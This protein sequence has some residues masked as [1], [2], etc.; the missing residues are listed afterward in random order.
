MS[1]SDPGHASGGQV[2]PD[3]APD[4]LCG[5]SWAVHKPDEKTAVRKACSH[6]GCGCRVYRPD[7]PV[8]VTE[9]A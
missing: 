1:A 2:Y 7:V 4:C 3:P 5:D 8:E 9:D 6:S